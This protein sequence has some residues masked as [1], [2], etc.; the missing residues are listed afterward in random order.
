MHRPLPEERPSEGAESASRRRPGSA[1]DVK[2]GALLEAPDTA[3]GRGAENPI[4]RTGVKAV[5]A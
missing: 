5:G 3:A 4:D 2:A 1:V